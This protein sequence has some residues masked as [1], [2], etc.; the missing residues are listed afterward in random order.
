MLTKTD[1]YLHL[2]PIHRLTHHYGAL[3]A[4][5]SVELEHLLEWEVTDDVRVED[6]ERLIVVTQ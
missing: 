2:L 1:F 5:V 3:V 4:M 6:E